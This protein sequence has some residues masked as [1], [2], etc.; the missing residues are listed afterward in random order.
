MS[1]PTRIE[2]PGAYY[3]VMNRG[4]HREVI[5]PDE[6][7][8]QLFLDTL[9]ETVV[10]FDLVVHAYCLMSNHYHLLVS[11]PNGNLQRAMRHLGGVYT[12]RYNRRQQLDGSL[13]RGR[14]KAILVDS[15]EY[16]LHV[17]KYIHQN[18]QE[19]SM[20]AN[21]QD[22]RWS[23]YPAYVNKA[24][25]AKW[26]T[27]SEVYDQLTQSRQKARRYRAYVEEIEPD[28]ELNS[29]YAKQ[30]LSP[31][32]G[33]REFRDWLKEHMSEEYS[34]SPRHELGFMK[35]SMAR[36]V[37]V[38][39][40]YYDCDVE[41]VTRSKRGRGASNYPRRMAMYLLQQVGDYKL[42][43]IAGFFDLAHYGSVGSVVS[44]MKKQAR[45]DKQCAKDINNIV[46]ILDP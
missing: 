21:L 6:T 3:H 26:L 36:I 39:A 24:R 9:E 33:G 16:L 17:S 46:N 22:Y 32:L 20:V 31:V 8:F 43:E 11:T 45:E 5:F 23:S 10:R 4:R 42:G 38:V 27:R 44:V 30:R 35:P 37:A 14:Y 1:R 13:F 2:Y 41:S 28:N 19:A 40:T 12:Q 18:P 25:A 34:Q 15:D 7:F 29:F